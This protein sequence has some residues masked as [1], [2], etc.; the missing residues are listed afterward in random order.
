[1]FEL[2][3]VVLVWGVSDSAPGNGGHHVAPSGNLASWAGD[4]ATDM[5]VSMRSAIAQYGSNVK[6]IMVYQQLDCLGCGD[7]L[8]YASV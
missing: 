3:A 1:M 8:R 4:K 5:H 2:A 6:P 7:P